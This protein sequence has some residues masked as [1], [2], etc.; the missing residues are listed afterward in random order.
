MKDTTEKEMTSEEMQITGLKM[1]MLGRNWPARKL[2]PEEEV[3]V[4]EY[5]KP[6]TDVD[7]CPW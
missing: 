7:D 1:L 4:E 5:L 6:E 3:A 2:T